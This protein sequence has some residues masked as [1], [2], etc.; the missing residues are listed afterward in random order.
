MTISVLQV[1][2]RLDEDGELE[3]YC[4]G[5]NEWWP[6]DSEFF[7]SSGH[8]KLAKLCKACYLEKYK[9]GRSKTHVNI[10]GAVEKV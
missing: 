1:G 10:K 3:K 8:G 7:Y 2:Q 6:A 4:P 5:C 9:A